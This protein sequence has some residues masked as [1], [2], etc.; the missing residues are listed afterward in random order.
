[1]VDFAAFNSD[2]NTQSSTLLGSLIHFIYTVKRIVD[3]IK[4]PSQCI[5]SYAPC[6]ESNTYGKW[7]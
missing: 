5:C 1:M 7:Y 3:N 4:T 2:T 6:L